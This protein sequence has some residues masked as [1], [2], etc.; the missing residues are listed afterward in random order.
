MP[1]TTDQFA[2]WFVVGLALAYFVWFCMNPKHAA[3]FLGAWLVIAILP[4]GVWC[5]AGWNGLIAYNALSNTFLFFL[6]FLSQ[7]K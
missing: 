6:A 4:Y 5:C 3:L 7:H 2:G 1:W